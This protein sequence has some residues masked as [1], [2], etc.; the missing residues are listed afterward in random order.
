MSALIRIGILSWCALCIG[1]GRADTTTEVAARIDEGLLK[2]LAL[3]QGVV[4][5]TPAAVPVVLPPL[6]D[7]TSF[8]RRACIDLAGRLPT[9]AEV[10]EFL[11]SDS[12]TKHADLID[13]LSLSREASN[14]RYLR[15]ADLMRVTDKVGERSLVPFAD[16]LQKSVRENVAWDELMKQMLLASGDQSTSPATGFLLRDDGNRLQT[17]VAVAS[18]LLGAD[19]HCAQCHDHAFAD[20]TQMQAYQFAACLPPVRG[21]MPA[22]MKKPKKPE[23]LLPGARRLG[24]AVSEPPSAPPDETELRKGGWFGIA[25]GVHDLL[26]GMRLP[27]D[28]KYVNGK[29]GDVVGP[30]LLVFTK[31]QQKALVGLRGAPTQASATREEMITT[32]FKLHRER[33]ARVMALRVWIWMF[34]FET[35]QTD[36]REGDAD[37]AESLA[38]WRGSCSVGLTNSLRYQRMVDV[39]FVQL[40]GL[41]FER[42][43]FDLQE[44]Q[45][46]IA[47]TVAYQRQAVPSPP[48]GQ[49]QFTAAPIVRRLPAGVIWDAFQQW[50]GS[51]PITRAVEQPAVVDIE[52]PLRLLG[53]GSREWTE[54]NALL[55]APGITRFFCNGGLVHQVEQKLASDA[56][57]ELFITIL[58]RPATT[59]ETTAFALSGLSAADAAWALINTTEFLFQH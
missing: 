30:A 9:A 59:D 37:L 32:L 6:A 52:H 45:R 48:M 19:L 49:A 47:R 50:L 34:G 36:W 4:G 26:P 31:W 20:W 23:T 53:R 38:E 56:F 5:R 13:R 44:F 7:E 41:E 8:I 39:P 11:A 16:W 3:E 35:A 24:R 25:E 29:P 27:N 57:E 28:Y 18:I 54:E 21:V 12:P 33:I 22:A 17:A 40:L 10:R 43:G 58:S 14:L 46:I 1:H 15:L 2:T 42:C 51:A 55:I